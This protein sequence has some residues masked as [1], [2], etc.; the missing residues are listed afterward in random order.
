MYQKFLV[1]IGLRTKCC[2]AKIMFWHHNQMYC[3]KCLAKIDQ[4]PKHKIITV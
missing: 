1:K 2:Q 4:Q 3:Q